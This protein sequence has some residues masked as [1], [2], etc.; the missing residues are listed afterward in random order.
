MASI[1][2]IMVRAISSFVLC[3]TIVLD[4][5]KATSIL[6]STIIV[7]GE[8]SDSSTIRTQPSPPDCSIFEK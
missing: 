5:S 3:V 8:S 2:V 4:V 7:V 6:V 1:E